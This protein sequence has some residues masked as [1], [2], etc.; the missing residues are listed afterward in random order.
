VRPQEK[1]CT[2]PRVWLRHTVISP[3]VSRTR[4]ILHT[5]GLVPAIVPNEI[6]T[7]D[8]LAQYLV[9]DVLI[10]FRAFLQLLSF[11]GKRAAISHSPCQFRHLSVSVTL[12][13]SDLMEQQSESIQIQN[14]ILVLP[15]TL[16]RQLPMLT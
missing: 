8:Y 6:R 16:L 14:L 7:F 5:E 1:L 10:S 11:V 12:G 3:G 15:Y 4:E 13:G 9:D 2:S